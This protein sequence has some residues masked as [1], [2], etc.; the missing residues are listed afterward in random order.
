M[1]V[2]SLYRYG[3]SGS[4][5]WHEGKSVTVR[6]LP[7]AQQLGETVVTGIYTRKMDSFTGAASTYKAEEL[8]AIGNQNIL[9]SLSALDPSFVIAENNLA[10]ADPNSMLDISINGKQVS[11]VCRTRTEPTPTGRFSFWMVLK[12]RWR[13]FPT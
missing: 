12:Q 4:A 8:K 11:T 1:L 2:F 13:G 6:M 10:G 3:V 7:D 9:Q 5:V